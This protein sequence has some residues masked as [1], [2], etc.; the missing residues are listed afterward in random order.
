MSIAELRSLPRA[1]KLKIIEALWADL[2]A[3]PDA[4]ESP[5]WHAAELASTATDFEAGKIEVLEWEDAK[6]ELSGKR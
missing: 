4:L 3:D 2:A 5:A 6:R 1:E